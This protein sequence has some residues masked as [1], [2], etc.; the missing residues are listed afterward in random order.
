M[1][2]QPKDQKISMIIFTNEPMSDPLIDNLPP[3]E[4]KR[5]SKMEQEVHQ[6]NVSYINVV[7]A[8]IKDHPNIKRPYNYL[9]VL[10]SLKGK[11]GECRKITKEMYKKFPDY[12]FAK[13]GYAK[14]CLL[15]D[16]LEEFDKIFEGK[17]NLA[18]IYPDRKEFHTSEFLAFTDLLCEHAFHVEDLDFVRNTIEA[19][20]K[21]SIEEYK[22]VF[23]N[24]IDDLEEELNMFGERPDEFIDLVQEFIKK[25]GLLKK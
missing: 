7:K 8:F 12:L 3:L 20:K 25:G 5:F 15:D 18:L 23:D 13:I 1:T 4:R 22:G 17:K 11:T 19:L 14:L 24:L 21:M 9:A 16:N 6:G 10:Y 2:Q